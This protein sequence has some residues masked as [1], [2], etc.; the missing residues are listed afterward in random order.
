LGVTG[1]RPI[2]MIIGITGCYCSGKNTLCE[3]F[4]KQGF[5]IIDVDRIGYIALEAKQ[6]EIIR[7][8]G[9]DILSEDRIDRKKLGSIIFGD[10]QKRNELEKI[11]HPWMIKKVKDLMDIDKNIIINA[12]LL[13]EMCLFVLCDVVIG[14]DVREDLAIE[15]GIERDR[16]PRDE[17]IN[18]LRAQIPLKEKLHYVDKIIENNHKIDEFRKKITAVYREIQNK[19]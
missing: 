18:R 7:I 5:S 12:A 4:A 10:P 15:R 6:T 16:L 2:E 19:M 13:I 11:V 9:E 3:L 1:K 8:F 14:I 17:V